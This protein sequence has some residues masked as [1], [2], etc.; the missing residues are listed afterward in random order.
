MLPCNPVTA[1]WKA[2][3]CFRVKWQELKLHF[4]VC[5]KSCGG[6]FASAP[7]VQQGFSLVT[8]IRV[9]VG[10]SGEVGTAFRLKER[11]GI[12]LMAANI[13]SSPAVLM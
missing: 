9:G 3:F 12:S 10:V 2:E 4:I 13:T 1:I 8:L 6:Y 7:L 5:K 11:S